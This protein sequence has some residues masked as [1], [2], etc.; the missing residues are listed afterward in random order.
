VRAV[1]FPG[2]LFLPLPLIGLF[3][4]ITGSLIAMGRIKF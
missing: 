4:G 3:L 2:E 1:A